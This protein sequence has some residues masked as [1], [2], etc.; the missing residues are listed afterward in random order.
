[1]NHYLPSP[2]FL[3]ESIRLSRLPEA[4]IFIPNNPKPSQVR[5]DYIETLKQWVKTKPDGPHVERWQKE[6]NN[7]KQSK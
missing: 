6:I 5:M 3:A 1:M 7:F 4:R 2:E